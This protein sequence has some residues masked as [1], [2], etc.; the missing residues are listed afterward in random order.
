MIWIKNHGIQGESENLRISLKNAGV[1]VV[2]V[3]D[4][5]DTTPITVFRRWTGIHIDSQLPDEALENAFLDFE[6]NVRF[7]YKEEAEHPDYDNK[8][9]ELD[10]YYD[11]THPDLDQS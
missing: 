3:K 5:G 2:T 4:D 9:D 8:S 6:E 10:A 1:P 7:A 11:G